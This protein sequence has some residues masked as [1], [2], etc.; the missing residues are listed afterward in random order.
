MVFAPGDA[1]QQFLKL[2]EYIRRHQIC[3]TAFGNDID[4]PPPSDVIPVLPKVFPS[5]AFDPVS[6]NGFSHFFRDGNAEAGT[7]PRRC[8]HGHEKGRVNPSAVPE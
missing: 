8:K 3:G 5:E 4:V 7:L 6:P 2:P 1:V